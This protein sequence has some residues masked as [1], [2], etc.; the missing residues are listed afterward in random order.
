[1]KNLDALMMIFIF[2]LGVSFIVARGMWE[3]R[4]YRLVKL[5][6]GRA[7]KRADKKAAL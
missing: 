3:A 5:Q 6:E 2:G 1:M 7:K 4:T